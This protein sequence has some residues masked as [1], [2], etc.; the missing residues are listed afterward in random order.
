MTRHRH[1]PHCG[2]EIDG[3]DDPRS[4]PQNNRYHALI[5][6]AFAHWPKTYTFQPHNKDHLRK[7]LEVEAGHFTVKHIEAPE[8]IDPAILAIFVRS[9]F[10]QA[11]VYVYTEISHRSITMRVPKSTR[12]SQLGHKAACKLFTEVEEI[13]GE[14]VGVTG[15][16]LLKEKAA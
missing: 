1:C 11:E 2:C 6:K 7:W 12:Y 3:D 4:T 9:M 14:I 10:R 15:D 16:Q 8:A 5:R 13:I